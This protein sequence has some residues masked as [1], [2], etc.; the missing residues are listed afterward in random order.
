MIYEYSCEK[1]DK[2][3]EVVKP[4]AQSSTKEYCG[5]CGNLLSMVFSKKT[6][7]VGT[8]VKDAEYYHS[9]GKVIKNDRQRKEEI[10]KHGLIEVGNE[11]PKAIRHHTE[12]HRL[13]KIAKDYDED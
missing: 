1:C 13:A 7:F 12:K 2:I 5:D 6:L 10:R 11:T 4:M 8:A 9:L 3:S